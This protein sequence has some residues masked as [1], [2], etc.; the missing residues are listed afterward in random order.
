MTKNQ[1]ITVQ[2]V[3]QGKDSVSTARFELYTCSY[4]L[5]K[6]VAWQ[7]ANGCWFFSCPFS[8]RQ[9]TTGNFLM[10]PSFSWAHYTLIKHLLVSHV[11]PGVLGRATRTISLTF[12]AGGGEKT[13]SNFHNIPSCDASI[14]NISTTTL[15]ITEV[16]KQAEMQR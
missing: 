8:R 16:E 11:F 4:S 5:R 13:A 12:L 2:M 10:C 15:R 1:P 14:C 3:S 6:P 7:R 9:A